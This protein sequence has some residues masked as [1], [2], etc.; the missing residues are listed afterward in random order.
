MDLWQKMGDL[1]LLG[2]TVGESYGGSDMGYL[3]QVIA[4]EEISRA[5]AS[6]GLSYGAHSNLCVNQIFRNGTEPRN[7][8]TCQ[9]SALGTM[10]APWL[11]RSRI[12]VRRRQHAAQSARE[13]CL[14]A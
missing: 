4:I 11:C 12:R 9:N 13:G 5:P 14:R 8:S 2:I 6:V 7:K 10:S 1:G 3:A